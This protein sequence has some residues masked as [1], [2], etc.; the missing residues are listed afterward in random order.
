MKRKAIK[1]GMVCLA[2]AV[3]PFSIRAESVWRWKCPELAAAARSVTVEPVKFGKSWA[4]ALEF[5]DGGTF[6][7]D[8]AVPIL[9]KF[10]YTD[11]PP[12]VSGGR[13]MPFVASVAV[14]PFVLDGENNTLL[15]WEQI[16]GLREKGWGVSNHSYWHTGNHW[17]PKDF[18]DEAQMRREL[19]W[20]Q[21]ILSHFLSGEKE[22]CRRFVYPS[23]DF[24]Y[25]PFLAE[26]GLNTTP[27]AFK[28]GN[29]LTA[30]IPPFDAES[31]YHLTN[32][33][34]MDAGAWDKRG[35][36]DMDSFPQ[37]R[38]APGDF[39]LDFTHG[40]GKAGE[41]N[42]LRW[43]RRLGKIS[44]EFG[45]GGDDSVWCGSTGEI[46]AYHAAAAKAR[47]GS[48]RSGIFV[49]VPEGAFKSPL[50]LKI[51]LSRP[52]DALP[53]PPPG[54]LVYRQGDQIWLT[55][56]PLGDDSAP[57]VPRAKPVHDGPFQEK[58]S[59]DKPVRLAAVR[60]LQ[61]GDPGAGFVPEITWVAKD[62]TNGRVPVENVLRWVPTKSRWG[63]WLLFPVVPDQPAPEIVELNIKPSPAFQKLELWATE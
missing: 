63:N 60:I 21:A 56:P 49:D 34:N 19:F 44:A 35:G 3:A 32:R 50:T 22:I 24:H 46:I 41:T 1:L 51:K 11:A 47:A 26:Y 33:N 58:I 55:T 4:Y 25:G 30:P 36:D 48:D 39:V 5:D 42:V 27:I 23:G 59:F 15:T 40:M 6:A 54:A 17:E 7:Q 61:K 2:T 37:P 45:S 16:R 62:G 10:I 52:L 28:N 29:S 57:G 12:G 20:S 31:K 13:K 9:E 8:I 14:Y 43:E 38:P 18:L 53:A